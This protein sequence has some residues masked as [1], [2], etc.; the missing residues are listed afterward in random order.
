MRRLWTEADSGVPAYIDHDATKAGSLGLVAGDVDTWANLGSLGGVAT[1]I[2]AGNRFTYVA[3]AGDGLPAVR[4]SGSDQLLSDQVI[5][6][7]DGAII[8]AVIRA[9]GGAGIHRYIAQGQNGYPENVQGLIARLNNGVFE[10]ATESVSPALRTTTRYPAD[11]G[12]NSWGLIQSSDLGH[13]SNNYACYRISGH[14]GGEYFDGD[15]R[16]IVVLHPSTSVDDVARWKGLLAWQSNLQGG[17][18]AG[19]PYREEP[20]YVDDGAT[21]SGEATIALDPVLVTAGGGPALTGAAAAGIGQVIAAGRGGPS[22]AG[23]ADVMLGDVASSAAGRLG[24]GGQLAVAVGAIAVQAA[25]SLPIAAS[26]LTALGPVTAAL[27]GQN[28][29]T[30]GAV[31][32]LGPVTLQATSGPPSPATGSMAAQLAAIAGAAAASNPIA[33][34]AALPLGGVTASG[35]GAAMVTGRA[36]VTIGPISAVAAGSLRLTGAA[37]GS[38]PAIA[39]NGQGEGDSASLDPIVIPAA[40]RFVVPARQ[41]RFVIPARQRAFF[42]RKGLC[43]SSISKYPAEERQ[44]QADW[45]ADLNGQSIVGEIAATSSD[46]A[47]LVDQVAYDGPLMKF[48]LRGGTSGRSVTVNF[49]ANTSGGEELAWQ[50]TVVVY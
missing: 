34:S 44:Y 8:L 36:T 7:P 46:P 6:I 30:G 35:I 18:A 40:H 11:G 42:I 13:I 37:V 5:I 31:A 25:G 47:L 1:A 20:P 3:D 39:L 10:V 32:M 27:T 22:L 48:W 23:R 33:G 16:R 2:G 28:T 4:S 29:V 17:F 45:S 50:Q 12:I 9:N 49:I 21:P 14:L 19:D 24:I 43:M 26:A 41:R 15:I 38:L